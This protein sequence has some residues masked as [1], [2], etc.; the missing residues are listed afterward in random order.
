MRTFLAL[1]SS[2]LELLQALERRRI[3]CPVRGPF[4]V[5]GMDYLAK[6]ATDIDKLI[7]GEAVGGPT[8]GGG[9]FPE[10]RIGQKE[11]FRS[12]PAPS[13]MGQEETGERG[14]RGKKQRTPGRGG[15]S[16]WPILD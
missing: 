1:R 2:R 3:L 4:L 9:R 12:T 5:G 6:M 8:G 16:S 11:S 14:R 7:R 10:F 13:G 15:G